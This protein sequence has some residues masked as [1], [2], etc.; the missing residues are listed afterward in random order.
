MSAELTLPKAGEWFSYCDNDVNWYCLAICPNGTIYAR[1]GGPHGGQI[2][3]FSGTE[4]KDVKVGPR[5]AEFLEPEE[6]AIP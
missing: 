2:T 3:T 1:Y 4:L 6:G 5:P